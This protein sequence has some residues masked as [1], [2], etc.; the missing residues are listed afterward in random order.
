MKMFLFNNTQSMCELNQKIDINYVYNYIKN[1]PWKNSFNY[2]KNYT[3]NIDWNYYFNFAIENKE[4]LFFSFQILVLMYIFRRMSSNKI[5]S[6]LYINDRLSYI[7]YNLRKFKLEKDDYRND[8]NI[9]IQNCL[10]TISEFE[11]KLTSINKNITSVKRDI[12]NIKKDI[13]DIDENIENF[14]FNIEAI[15][16]KL[17]RIERNSKIIDKKSVLNVS[18][19]S[20]KEEYLEIVN[21][22]IDDEDYTDDEDDEDYTDDDL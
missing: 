2:I 18:P 16:K 10:K 11:K 20:E 19:A 9:N 15:E 8:T 3:D 6:R 12:T 17:N 13:K 22:D 21:S 14:E 4:S 1:I 5:D 7:E